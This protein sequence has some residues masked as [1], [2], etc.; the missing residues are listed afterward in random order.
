MEKISPK[1]YIETKAR[2]LPIYKCL[3]TPDWK[4]MDMANVIIMRKHVTGNVTLG[5]YLIDLLCLGVKDTFYHFNASEAE[6][7]ER[8]ES[9]I[10]SLEECDYDLAHNVIYAAHDFAMEFDIPPHKDFKLTKYILQEDDDHVPLIDIHTGAPDG[11]PHL[12]INPQG[13][14]K[15][16]LEKLIKNAGEGNYYYTT[17]DDIGDEGEDDESYAPNENIDDYA[18]NTISAYTAKFLRIEDI[19]DAKKTEKRNSTEI[20]SLT[21]EAVIRTLELSESVITEADF[22][23]TEEYDLVDNCN[24]HI[25]SK[26]GLVFL[27]DMDEDGFI[28][29]YFEEI[30]GLDGKKFVNKVDGLMAEYNANFYAMQQLYQYVLLT[31]NEELIKKVCNQINNFTENY[32]LAKI[33]LAFNSAYFN[34]PDIRVAPIL[35]ST[36][37]QNCFPE[38]YTFGADELQVY[39]L[40]KTLKSIG[41]DNLEG[42]VFYYKLGVET[43]VENVFFWTTQQKLLEYFN[44]KMESAL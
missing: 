1:K 37:I 43:C 32:P 14:G 44:Y 31:E 39:W 26:D 29:Q 12:M 20:S 34:L 16:A 23:K 41:D 17:E 11:K 38:Y 33:I 9:I 30:S 40:A 22:V 4:E 24:D 8:L 6:A 25:N 2:S 28:K 21:I 10:D 36:K 19:I 5:Y 27:E 35:Y 13:Q 7:E 18:P 42:T 15:W 3:I